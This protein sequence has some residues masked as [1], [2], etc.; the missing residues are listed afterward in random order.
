MSTQASRK[1]CSR[2]SLESLSQSIS[3]LSHP[4]FG[5]LS[6]E[7]GSSCQGQLCVCDQKFVYCLKRNMRSYN[8]LYQYFPNFLCT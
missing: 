7:H 8:P 1:S 3:L 4:S 6:T 2:A 5:I